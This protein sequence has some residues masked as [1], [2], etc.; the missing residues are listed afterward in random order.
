MEPYHCV[1]WLTGTVPIEISA[2]YVPRHLRG[3]QDAQP[4]IQVGINASGG[5]PFTQ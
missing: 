2:G 1:P 4:H 3:R 5:E